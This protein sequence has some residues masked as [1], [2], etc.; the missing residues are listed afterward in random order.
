MLYYSTRDK[1]RKYPFRLKDAAFAGLAPDGGLFMPEHYPQVD[2]AKVE[3]LAD[4][5]F[6]SMA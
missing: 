3:A 6:A 2:M 4:E 1:E 5:S